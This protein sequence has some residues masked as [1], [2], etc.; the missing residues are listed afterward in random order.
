M[1]RSSTL[2]LAACIASVIVA[3]CGGG[4]APATPTPAP[5]TVA[6]TAAATE[7]PVATP[8]STN[9]ST[10][11]PSVKGP[12]Q[13]SIGQKIDVAWTGPNAQGDFV[14][15]VAVGT[16]KWTNET[17][18]YTASNPSPGS[19][20]APG[21]AGAFEIWYVSGADL[22]VLARSPLTVSAFVGS[23]DAPASVAGGTEFAISWTG[24]NGQGD[25]ITIVKAGTPAWTNEP[26]FYTSVG[27]TSK[28]VAPIDAGPYELLYISGQG[29]TVQLRRPI[30]VTAS[31]ATVDGPGEVNHGN[32]VSIAWTGPSGPGDYI[33]IAPK[34]SSDGTYTDYCYTTT[35]SPCV[36]NAPDTAGPYEVRYVTG[37]GR[38]IA[39]E[40]LLVK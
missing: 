23:I 22:T 24:P 18:F 9:A 34:G 32:P 5:A 39:S 40:P 16:A 6:P 8:A 14:T 35:P 1:V 27:P 2:R 33:T 20:T 13:A 25:Y 28:L 15:I 37:T 21:T 26:Y 31:S 4:G 36:I 12:A 11:E 38:M 19:L 30:T 17:Y 10:G 3:A 29:A 7:A